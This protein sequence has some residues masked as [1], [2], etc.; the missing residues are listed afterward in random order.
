MAHVV[1]MVFARAWKVGLAMHVISTTGDAKRIAMLLKVMGS[2]F[3]RKVLAL[4]NQRNV[5][6]TKAGAER[7]VVQS[8]A[9]HF[10]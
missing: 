2:A 4:A 9:T 8:C 10:V 6:A 7:T 5:F 1:Q 3:L